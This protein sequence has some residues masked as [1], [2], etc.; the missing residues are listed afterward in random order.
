MLYGGETNFN[1]K[2]LDRFY[3]MYLNLFVISIS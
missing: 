3:Q 1:N 2:P